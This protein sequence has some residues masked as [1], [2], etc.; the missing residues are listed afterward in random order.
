MKKIIFALS[1]LLIICGCATKKDN[2][3][4]A[5]ADYINT[6]SIVDLKTYLTIIASDEM[7]GR[8]TGSEGQKKA[9][10]FD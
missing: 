7:E 9:G 2:S 10:L 6:I 1:L 3:N 4:K 8:E 5:L